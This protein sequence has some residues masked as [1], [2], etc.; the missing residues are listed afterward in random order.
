[1]TES[2]LLSE[3]ALMKENIIVP[4][5]SYIMDYGNEVRLL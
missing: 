1:M 3:L 2:W 5:V 4:Y